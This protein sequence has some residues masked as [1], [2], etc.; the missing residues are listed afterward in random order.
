MAQRERRQQKGALIVKKV[1]FPLP[2]AVGDRF[3]SGADV[4]REIVLCR[5]GCRKPGNIKIALSIADKLEAEGPFVF[6]DREHELLTE[7]G[8]LKGVDSLAPPALNHF[9]MKVLAAIYEAETAKD[10]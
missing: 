4:L 2:I 1:T 7:E 3:W 8:A 6:T 10:A 5:Q 9:Y